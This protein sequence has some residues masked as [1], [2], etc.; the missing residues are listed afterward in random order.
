MRKIKGLFLVRSGG[1]AV[2]VRSGTISLFVRF[3]QKRVSG[4][5]EETQLETYRRASDFLRYLTRGFIQTVST[6][7]G[8]GQNKRYMGVGL[9]E[10]FCR[11]VA[12]LL[13]LAC[14]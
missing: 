8:K 2:L 9:N 14:L 1:G 11:D 7:Q 13:I 5:E 6:S 4:R 10:D 3:Y 12:A